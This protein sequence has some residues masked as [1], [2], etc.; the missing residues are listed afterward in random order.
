MEP[1]APAR[2]E[3]WVRR[4]S[5]ARDNAASEKTFARPDGSLP[6]FCLGLN[7]EPGEGPAPNGA[8]IELS[9][10]E[11]ERLDVREIRYLRVDV[12][13]A[14]ASDARF[15]TVYAYTARPE[16]HR[17]EPPPGA[18]IV[19]SYPRTVEAAFDTLGQGEL[20][21]YRETTAPMPVEPVE[22]TLIADRIPPGN[23][24][25]W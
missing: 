9:Q 10:V 3:N 7:V 19:A 17:P 24:R 22:A 23:P 15:D 1:L 25:A 5:L 16:H 11:L 6:T 13:A 18:I 2:L 21:L 12:T 14:I 20:S 4:W 8:L